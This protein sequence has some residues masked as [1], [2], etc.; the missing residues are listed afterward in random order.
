MRLQSDGKDTWP[1]REL[2]SHSWELSDLE[3]VSAG[4]M[5]FRSH[6]VDEILSH[7]RVTIAGTTPVVQ[8]QPQITSA[9]SEHIHLCP[10]IDLFLAPCESEALRWHLTRRLHCT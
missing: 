2:L 3:E 8:R 9:Q 7:S 4:E 10:Q 6:V 1:H 5:Y